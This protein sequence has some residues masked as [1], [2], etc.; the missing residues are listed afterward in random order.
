MSQSTSVRRVT[1]CVLFSCSVCVRMRLLIWANVAVKVA[2]SSCSQRCTLISMNLMFECR[3]CVRVCVCVRLT[4]SLLMTRDE[5]VPLTFCWYWHITRPVKQEQMNHLVGFQS[6][7]SPPD[8]ISHHVRLYGSVGV[9][10]PCGLFQRSAAVFTATPR[11]SQMS[12]RV[13][14]MSTTCV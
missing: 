9:K 6:R 3:F 13:Q 8:C 2:Y 7:T 14:R 10:S 5:L 11:F 1:L 4:M 12:W